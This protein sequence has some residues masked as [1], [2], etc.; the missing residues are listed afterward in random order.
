MANKKKTA[1]R[2]TPVQRRRREKQ[3]HVPGTAPKVHQDILDA[4]EV[5]E[6]ADDAKTAA[7]ADYTAATEALCNA[8]SEH[9]LTSYEIDDVIIKT[10]ESST[11]RSA[12]VQRVKPKKGDGGDDGKGNCEAAE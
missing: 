8:M 5:W 9:N 11:K 4:A 1:N 6:E 2:K 7:K 12:K 10:R 3:V